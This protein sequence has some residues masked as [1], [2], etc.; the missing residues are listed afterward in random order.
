MTESGD[1]PWFAWVLFMLFGVFWIGCLALMLIRPRKWVEWFLD[2]PYRW[3]GLKV[4]M[5]DE[6]CF[7]KVT[8]FYI[9]LI[10]LGALIGTIAVILAMA[11]F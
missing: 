2:R 10:L 9:A 3:M 11:R 8:R 7:R 5:V 4:I 1:V 6:Q